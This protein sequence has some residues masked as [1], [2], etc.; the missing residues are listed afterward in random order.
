MITS[1][2]SP[3]NK[4]TSAV[5]MAQTVAQII[6]WYGYEFPRTDGPI[7]KIIE[8]EEQS[9]LTGSDCLD[10][11]QLEQILVG[12]FPDDETMAEQERYL[13][14]MGRT[15]GGY[16]G[17][18]DAPDHFY[19]DALGLENFPNLDRDRVSWPEILQLHHSLLDY[20]TRAKYWALA[21]LASAPFSSVPIVRLAAQYQISFPSCLLPYLTARLRSGILLREVASF[22][23]AGKPYGPH[24]TLRE[25]QQCQELGLFP[26]ECSILQSPNHPMRYVANRSRNPDPGY[27]VDEETVLARLDQ[28]MIRPAHLVEIRERIK[29][30]IIASILDHQT[31]ISGSFLSWALIDGA[32]AG[33]ITK[34]QEMIQHY[35]KSDLDMPTTL[36][37]GKTAKR[38]AA[39]LQDLF[40]GA[41]TITSDPF[42]KVYVEVD[43]SYTDAEIIRRLPSRYRE[44]SCRVIRCRD[45]NIGLF[46]RRRSNFKV[47]RE[48]K[49]EIRHPALL[50]EIQVYQ[51]QP[52]DVPTD[53]AMDLFS[54]V[55]QYH[56]ECARGMITDQGIHLS[57]LAAASLIHG[58]I[59]SPWNAELASSVAICAKYVQRGHQMYY[60]QG[61]DCPELHEAMRDQ[62]I[63]L[64]DLETKSSSLDQDQ[65]DAIFQFIFGSRVKRAQ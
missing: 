8:L 42:L 55:I 53:T 34:E 23:T 31:V 61:A 17:E 25:M 56:F 54:H 27:L 29:T 18:K 58:T 13:V 50:R 32:R 43:Q 49:I 37:A 26:R 44:M 38:I 30:P 46:I 52:P 57:F 22:T 20:P 62:E 5:I 9:R 45:K 39:L 3:S 59:R 35:Q 15:Y 2:S 36:P 63:E 4:I 64:G 10:R 48:E 21:L 19:R 51:A 6:D 1:L 40:G 33:S 11:E 60:H 47:I 7:A 12:F 16:D 14:M 65:K 24:F 28:F 41:A